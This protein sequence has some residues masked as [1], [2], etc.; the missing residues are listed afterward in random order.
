[1]SCNQMD[2]TA[3]ARLHFAAFIHLVRAGQTLRWLM[4]KVPLHP[5]RL[6]S[7]YQLLLPYKALMCE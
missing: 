1:M 2:Q 3:E 6:S 5:I 7:P 4:A